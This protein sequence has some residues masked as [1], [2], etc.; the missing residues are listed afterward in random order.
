[1][2]AIFYCPFSTFYTNFNLLECKDLFKCL[3]Y[4]KKKETSAF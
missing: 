1:M 3:D 2:F 4:I